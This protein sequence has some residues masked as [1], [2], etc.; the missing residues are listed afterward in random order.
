MLQP[1][2]DWSLLHSKIPTLSLLDALREAGWEGA[3]KT[4]LH[5]ADDD[6]LSYDSR[7]PI[8]KKSYY[9]CLLVRAE[10]FGP[11]V[12]EFRSDRPKTYFDYLLKF[13]KLPPEGKSMK[14]LRKLMD[15]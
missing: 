5:R 12:I 13:K 6:R 1:P 10:L 11:D 14:E 7:R 4:L 9:K 8:P 3:R 15:D 2:A